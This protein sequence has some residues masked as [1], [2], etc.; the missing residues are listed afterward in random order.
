MTFIVGLTGGIG[1]GKTSAANLF[2][3]SGAL[4][5]DTD[6]IAHDL[7]RPGGAAIPGI[8]AAFGPDA[9]QDDGR[10]N[11]ARMRQLVFSD[12]SAKECLEAIL[13][14]MI[15]A[16]TQKRCL[17]TGAPYIVLVIPLLFETGFCRREINRILLVDC[18]EAAQ[19]RRVMARNGLS[20][21]E[22][23]AIM[24]AQASRAARLAA[25]DDI[26]LNDGGIKMLDRQ[27]A[28]L[29]QK[30]VKLARERNAGLPRQIDDRTRDIPGS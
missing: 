1:S 13:H 20:F 7:T 21:G 27:I 11:R 6:A 26:I 29:H 14:P 17:Q 28:R 22:V 12:A 3:S 10:L 18:D 9:V 5:V 16:E 23:C 4:V 30:Y 19:K 8:R 24:A 25:A 2:S 15:H